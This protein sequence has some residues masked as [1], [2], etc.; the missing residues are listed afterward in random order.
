MPT[1]FNPT[2]VLLYL[3]VLGL[4]IY[5]Q[6]RPQRMSVGRFWI[7]PV[8][9]VVLTAWMMWATLAAPIPGVVLAG[10]ISALVGLILGIPLGIA[11]GHH[12]QVRLCE[13]PGVFFVD[14]SLIVSLI[15][16]GAF[17]VRFIVRM[18]VPTAGPVALGLTDGLVVFAVTSVI[19]ARLIIFRKYQAL[20]AAA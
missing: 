11:R 12:S 3:A 5:R 6:S 18:Y 20:A 15:W 1:H 9:V 7:F 2:S 19:T 16:L 13:R 17:V 8:L 14:P 4:I 10:S